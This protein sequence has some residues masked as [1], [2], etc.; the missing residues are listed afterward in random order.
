M[1]TT[2]CHCTI[3]SIIIACVA[4]VPAPAYAAGL[5]YDIQTWKVDPATTG[6][7]IEDHRTP[8]VQLRIEF[9]IGVWSPWVHE[10]HAEDAW[11]IQISM[12]MRGRADNLAAE[13]SSSMN[14][15]A[16]ILSVTCRKEDIKDILT[17][18]RDILTNKNLDRSQLDKRGRQ[19]L[20]QMSLKDPQFV[21]YQAA[22]R[23]MFA[24]DDP[25]RR[26]YEKPE[27]MLTDIRKLATVRDVVVR[28]PGRAIGFAGDVTRAEAESWARDL[29]P[30]ASA[31]KPPGILPQLL[32]LSSRE[33]RPSEQT[34]TLPRLTQVYFAYVRESLAFANPDR[35]AQMIA[36]S[37]LQEQLAEALRDQ[38][39]DT[40][41]CGVGEV[42][43]D[44]TVGSY[45][46][47]TYTR[48]ANASSIERKLRQAV[49]EF[50]EH[51]IT[52]KERAAAAGYLLGRR[53][54]DRQTP[55][56]VLAEFLWEHWQRMPRGFRDQLAERAAALSLDDV[57]VF[58]RRFYDPA[59]FTMIRVAP[60]K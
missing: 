31:Q 60:G 36:D 27:T 45:G 59:Q 52:E 2:I 20:R 58:I 5:M 53:A 46:V 40:Y 33:N 12:A 43:S 4:L 29:L 13:V 41:W 38:E 56:Q 42:G 50:F 48:T 6:A 54:F 7:L 26:P 24:R 21:L 8:L 30:P 19:M 32:P 37:V 17:L 14:Q 47:F 10:N 35:S 44:F 49:K 25:R 11:Q 39:G 55:G 34:V 22:N 28:L 57:N 18:V 3:L 16:S 1:K 15:W 23:L 9:P 51:G